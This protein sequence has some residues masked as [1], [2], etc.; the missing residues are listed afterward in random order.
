MVSARINEH[1][2]RAKGHYNYTRQS[3]K[4]IGTVAI[5]LQ[6]EL[7]RHYTPVVDFV[8]AELT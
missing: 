8:Q 3:N 5:A 2:E 6:G 4:P 1:G 7:S